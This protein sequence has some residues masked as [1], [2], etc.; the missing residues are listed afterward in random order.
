MIKSGTEIVDLLM[1][2]RLTGQAAIADIYSCDLFYDTR[3][4]RPTGRALL[5]WWG[6]EVWD[7]P[8][9]TLEGLDETLES[10]GYV[11]TSDWRER[12][13]ASGVVRYF[14]DAQVHLADCPIGP[15]PM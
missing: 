8:T 7:D 5:D 14:A 9:P 2:A 6:A 13:T 12:V 1:I 10:L 4:G 11:R 3:D 15:P